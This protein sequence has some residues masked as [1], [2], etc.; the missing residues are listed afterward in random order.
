MTTAYL[1]SQITRVIDFPLELF[2]AWDV[3]HLGIT[4]GSNGCNQAVIV[5]EG[6]IVVDKPTALIILL[7]TIDFDAEFCLFFKVVFFPDL[8]DLADNLLAVGIAA[9]PF[10][11]GM[12][13]VHEGVNLEARCVIDSLHQS[14]ST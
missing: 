2:H 11:G 5:P 10:D 13:S 7:D 9:L 8:L 14:I 4:T 1:P 3:R 12:E 6:R